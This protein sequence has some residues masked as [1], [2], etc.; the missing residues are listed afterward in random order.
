MRPSTVV[1]AASAPEPVEHDPFIDDLVPRERRSRGESNEWIVTY[2]EA[3][4]VA[5]GSYSVT[6][7]DGVTTTARTG[8]FICR[9]ASTT[10]RAGTGP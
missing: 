4:I 3:L 7:A 6:S 8:E 1:E 10:A 5:R 2:D 9:C